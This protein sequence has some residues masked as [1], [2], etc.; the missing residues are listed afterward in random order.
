VADAGPRLVAVPGEPETP[1]S[2]VPADAPA[3]RGVSRRSVGVVVVIAALLGVALAVQSRRVGELG[4]QV[5]GLTIELQ[6]AQAALA[7]H[8]RRMVR[9]RAS[10]DDLQARIANLSDLVDAP[11]EAPPP[12]EI[13]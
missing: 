11:P 10:V 7:A 2:D 4:T 6:A 5:E 9:V 1:G 12:S 8:E 3:A 13:P